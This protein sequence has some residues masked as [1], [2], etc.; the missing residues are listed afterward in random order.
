MPGD[1]LTPKQAAFVREY[2]V[3]LNAT[4]AYKRAGYRASGNAAEVNASRLLRNAKVAAAVGAAIELR[5]ERVELT[6]AEVLDELRAIGFDKAEATHNRLSALKL[7]GQ[8]LRLFTEWHAHT[9]DGEIMYGVVELPAETEGEESRPPEEMLER[10]RAPELAQS[11][12]AGLAVHVDGGPPL[13]SR[14]NGDGEAG[15]PKRGKEIVAEARARVR[16]KQRRTVPLRD[17]V[18]LPDETEGEEGHP[19]DVVT[20]D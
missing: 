4:A 17:L 19:A 12:V 18:E 5:A 7:L 2:L 8:H 1:Q 13:P 16:A 20:N 9:H 14:H 15:A 11:G 3:D 6:A 10:L